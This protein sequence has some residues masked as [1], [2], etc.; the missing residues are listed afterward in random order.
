MSVGG[1]SERARA[2]GSRVTRNETKRG[3]KAKTNS[4]RVVRPKGRRKSRRL[5]TAGDARG[6]GAGRSAARG[7][8]AEEGG[9]DEAR[10]GAVL[11]HAGGERRGLFLRPRRGRLARGGLGLGLLLLGLRWRRR[12][13][14]GR[15]VSQN[16][17]NFSR[18]LSRRGRAHGARSRRGGPVAGRAR[19]IARDPRRARDRERASAGRGAETRFARIAQFFSRIERETGIVFRRARRGATGRRGSTHRRLALALVLVLRNHLEYCAESVR[20]RESVHA[21]CARNERS[22]RLFQT[23][24]AAAVDVDPSKG[25]NSS[26]EIEFQRLERG[27]FRDRTR[28][29]FPPAFVR[30]FRLRFF[31]GGFQ[32]GGRWSIPRSNRPITIAIGA[33]SRALLA[34]IKRTAR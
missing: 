23:P 24:F 17:S 34:A 29:A 31:H 12:G 7:S 33:A 28:V 20:G 8:I 19:R 27:T 32:R 9:W 30:R 26:H 3:G 21:R 14:C 4:P 13:G 16:K 25:Q 18:V 2:L 5:E 15:V 6:D 1:G 22:P 10:T 11:F